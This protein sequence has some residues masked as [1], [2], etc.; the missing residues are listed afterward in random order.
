MTVA[1]PKRKPLD[2]FLAELPNDAAEQIRGAAAIMMRNEQAAA[3]LRGIELELKPFFI[4]ATISFVVGVIV[5]LFYAEPGGLLDR[6]TGAWPLLTAAL[7]FLPAVLAYY[8]A[9][10]RKRSQ[11]DMQNF[12]LNKELFLPH[13]AIYFPSDS[14]ADEQ[15]VTLIE[16]QEARFRRPSRWDNV[17]PGAIW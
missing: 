1:P 11:A 16:V 2:Q 10:I 17:K 5:L 15:M 14:E 8:A 9:R 13:G 7:G 4:A 3:R 12:D 6:I